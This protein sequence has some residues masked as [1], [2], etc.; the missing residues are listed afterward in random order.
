MEVLLP[1]SN[2]QRH[3]TPSHRA[4]T[5]GNSS[6]MIAHKMAPEMMNGRRR[7]HLGLQCLSLAA[8]INGWMSRPVTGPAKFRIGS[9]SGVAPMSVN[10]GF[11]AVCVKP[12]LY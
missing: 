8:P 3:I 6:K 11:T 2:S 9:S 4:E 5:N 1:A 7:P 10:S 12:K